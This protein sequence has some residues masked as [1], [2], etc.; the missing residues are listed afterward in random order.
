M[1]ARSNRIRVLL[2]DDH[3][4]VRE[5]IKSHLATL[6]DFEVLG[7]AGDGEEAVRLAAKLRP[8]IVLM[9]ISMPG[10][11]GLEAISRLRK[12]LPRVQVLVLTMHDDREY[13][14]KA[15]R[16]GARGFLRKNDSPD[17]L[18]LALRTI[19]SGEA[20]FGSGITGVLADELARGGT[21]TFDTE[22]LAALS[23]REREVLQ[24]IAEGLTNKDISRQLGVSVRT[25]ET[26]REH[27]MRKLNIHS[28]AGLTRFA[29]AQGII[30]A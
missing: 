14:A 13:V 10:M 20:Y 6:R 16:L 22:F 21:E 19:A 26:H 12:R 25:V 3:P 11:S 30:R 23:E 7:E 17:E 5:G 2:A 28:V 1:A 18:V 24:H 4:F 9:D 15:F 29:I 8:E 27:V